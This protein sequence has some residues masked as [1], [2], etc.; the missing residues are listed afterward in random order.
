MFFLA[1]LSVQSL[2]LFSIQSLALS[3][4]FLPEPEL[5]AG[6]L[7]LAL[8]TCCFF[9]QPS[10]SNNNS[11]YETIKK[12]EKFQA[13]CAITLINSSLSTTAAKHSRVPHNH[14]G[15]SV[16]VSVCV[17]VSNTG[18]GRKEMT[19][20]MPNNQKKHTSRQKQ[21]CRANLLSVSGPTSNSF[22]WFSYS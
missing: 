4:H 13:L 12:S 8:L 3:I 11:N 9:Q 19:M 17:S 1:F 15:V 2:C 5:W 20:K 14:M 21:K 22:L 10:N 7:V 18:L 6:V 16:C